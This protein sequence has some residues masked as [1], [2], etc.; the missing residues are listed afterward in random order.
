MGMVDEDACMR[1]ILP[2]MESKFAFQ[3]ASFFLPLSN[4]KPKSYPWL[5]KCLRGKPRYLPNLGVDRKP[6]MSTRF[7]LKSGSTLGEKYTRDFAS[8]MVC[9][10]FLQN[11]SRTSLIYGMAITLISLSKED[12]II[13]K[14]DMRE[15]GATS[16]GF[17]EGPKLGYT[18]FL[19]KIT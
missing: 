1:T 3:P 11:T 13:H 7:S 16:R 5:P 8:L 15:S 6:R 12:K 4:T 14:E 9:P 17:Y 19:N 18:F 2:T 10:D